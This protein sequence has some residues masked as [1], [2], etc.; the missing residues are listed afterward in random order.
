M[1]TEGLRI[2][3]DNISPCLTA[4]MREDINKLPSQSI[5]VIPVLTPDRL[6]KRQNGRRFKTDGEPMFTLTSQDKH[7]IFNGKTI[8]RLTPKEC[9]RLQG[10]LKDEINLDDISDKK[11]YQLAGNGW[12]ITVASKIF[13][14]LFKGDI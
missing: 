10:F 14:K 5:L 9:F 8:R 11:Q 2:R 7:G 6:E 12:E 13:K 4:T 1:E 3:E